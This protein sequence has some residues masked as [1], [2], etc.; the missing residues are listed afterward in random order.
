MNTTSITTFPKYAMLGPG[1]AA[2]V[3]LTPVMVSICPKHWQED[4]VFP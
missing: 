1:D 2:V 3:V 4:W